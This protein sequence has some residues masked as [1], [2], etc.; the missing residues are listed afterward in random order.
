MNPMQLVTIFYF[1]DNDLTIQVRQ[2][3]CEV[4]HSGRVILPKCFKENRQVLAVC[5]GEVKVLNKAGDRIT[6]YHT[7][8]R[9]I[10]TMHA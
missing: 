9:S 5:E 7:Y 1:D 3:Y 10:A 2:G 6:P 8:T 4:T